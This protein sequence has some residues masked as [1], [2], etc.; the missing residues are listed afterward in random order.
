[1]AISSLLVLHD[2]TKSE[3][4]L[5][6]ENECDDRVWSKPHEGRNKALEERRQVITTLY[7]VYGF[8]TFHSI[9]GFILY[10]VYG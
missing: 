2:G 3:P 4:N 9:Y 6:E 7:S 5:L 8:L 1:L 10:S